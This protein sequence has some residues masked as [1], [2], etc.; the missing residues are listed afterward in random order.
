MGAP[1][2]RRLLDA[3]F[4]VHIWNRSADKSA[5]LQKAGASVCDSP[6]DVARHADVVCLCVTD[7]A[8]VETVV[9]G[10]LGIVHG[11]RRDTI[12]VDFSSIK[13]DATREMSDR[14]YEVA[15]MHWVD[16]PVSGGVR[17]ATDGTLIIMCGG[18]DAVIERLAPVFDVVAERTTHMGNTGAGQVTKLCN[19]VIVS[20]NLLAISEA[21]LL[22][23]L[24]GIRIDRL[25]AALAGGW[26]DSLPL[27]IIGPLIAGH[28]SENRLGALATMLKDVA[29]ALEAAGAQGSSM[30]LT[31]E[32]VATYQD[33]C[34]AI[35]DDADISA[36]RA[37]YKIDQENGGQNG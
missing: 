12:L 32:V 29:V 22:G 18:D 20:S 37:F 31:R 10:E 36:L 11:A 5:A 23:Q 9:F 19:Q 15:D 13:P 21:L 7:T 14:L 30:R 33:A 8:A 4:A 28:A 35:G 27:Q 2:V 6:A 3:G 25:P 1:M 26:A 16:A 24:S 34:S 17:G